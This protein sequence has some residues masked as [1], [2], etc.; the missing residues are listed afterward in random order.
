MDNRPN[1][2]SSE[3]TMDLLSTDQPKPHGVGPAIGELVKADIDQ[4]IEKGLET[5]GEKLR[6]HNGR[7]PLIDAYEEVLDLANYLRQELYE[8]YGE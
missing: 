6:A 4:R 8:R 1:I 7:D 3:V 5:Y 2:L